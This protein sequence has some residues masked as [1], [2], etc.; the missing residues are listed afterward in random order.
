M[1]YV[2]TF[3]CFRGRLVTESI[4]FSDCRVHVRDYIPT[5]CEDACGNFTKFTSEVELEYIFAHP[6]LGTKMY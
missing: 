2:L 3:L 6:Q 1:F 4:L 5:V